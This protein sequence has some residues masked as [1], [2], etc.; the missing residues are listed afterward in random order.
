MSFSQTAY[1]CQRFYPHT[2]P[3]AGVHTGISDDCIL[4][5]DISKFC[6]C[7]FEVRACQWQILF[8]QCIIKW[9]KVFV[10]YF[11][12]CI[13]CVLLLLFFSWRN[14]CMIP[15]QWFCYARAKSI[16]FKLLWECV[17]QRLSCSLL[18]VCARVFSHRIYIWSYCSLKWFKILLICSGNGCKSPG[19]IA[20]IAFIE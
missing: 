10:C 11:C 20:S 13:I 7:S 8:W 6:C 4:L 1:K 2:D 5:P 14:S 12:L 16:P 19:F 18:G 17:G 15:I 3:I 9:L